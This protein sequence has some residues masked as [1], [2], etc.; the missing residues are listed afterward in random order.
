MA[1]QSDRKRR[2][3]RL[4]VASLVILGL[5]LSYLGYRLSALNEGIRNSYAEWWVADMV[6]EYLQANHDAW[7]RGW[8]DLRQ[9]YENCVKRSGRPW[10]FEELQARV[11]VDWQADPKQLAAAAERQDTTFRVIWPRDGTDSSWEL[12]K[13]N[14]M[15]Y[16]Y[17]REKNR[18]AGKKN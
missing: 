3:A 17:F 10:T 2:F 14:Q 4:I 11:D 7:P 5:G 18:S 8:S 13:P 16:D 6:I 1:A 15:I 9:P 12:H